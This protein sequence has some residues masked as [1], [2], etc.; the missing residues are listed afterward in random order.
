M[1]DAPATGVEFVEAQAVPTV[2][3]RA[4]DYPLEQMPALFD[5]TF[6]ALFPALAQRGIAPAG[7]PF[8]LHHRVPDAT[9]DIEVGIPLAEPLGASITVGDVVLTASELPAGTIART[10]YVGGYDGLGAAWGAFLGEV[11]AS[12]RAPDVPFWEVYV[13][14]PSPDADPATMRTDLFT[15][16]TSSSSD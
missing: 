12:G 6:G 15:R 9:A 5:S 14:E 11:G 4:T 8:S 1:S 10:T 16:V 13:T 3:V 2:V 7:I